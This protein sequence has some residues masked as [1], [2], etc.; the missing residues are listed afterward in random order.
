MRRTWLVT[1]A[2]RHDD[3]GPYGSAPPTSI[4][5]LN[6]FDIGIDVRIA[7]FRAMIAAVSDEDA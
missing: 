4:R 1:A 2:R 7:F 5:P 6:V 3:G